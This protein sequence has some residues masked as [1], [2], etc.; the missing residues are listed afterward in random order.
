[1]PVSKT[2]PVHCPACTHKLDVA[3]L[4]CAECGTS[5]EGDFALPA[6]AQLPKED[7]EFLLEFIKS[8]GSLKEMAKFT[9]HSY[10]KVRN[11]LDDIIQRLKEIE[12]S[13]T[14]KS[15]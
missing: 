11:T 14:T 13:V 4:S 7:I 6:L 9:G 10:P 2:I 1:M 5:V 12:A 15:K 3:K 8:S